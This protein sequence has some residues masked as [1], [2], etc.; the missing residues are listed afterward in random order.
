MAGSV[1]MRTGHEV[2]DD[3]IVHNDRAMSWEEADMRAG[4]HLD[5]RK[6]WAFIP[7]TDNLGVPELCERVSFSTECSGCADTEEFYSSTSKG[8]GCSECGYTGRSRR[9]CFVPHFPAGDPA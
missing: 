3:R 8:G 4:F 6:S 7:D 5:R 2:V 1:I 9:V